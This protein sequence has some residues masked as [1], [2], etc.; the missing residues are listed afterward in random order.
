MI[1]AGDRALVCAFV[2]AAIRDDEDIVEKYEAL[3]AVDDRGKL[4]GGFVYYNYE[5]KP[6]GGNVWIACAGH[7]PW[8]TRQNLRVW[9]EYPFVQLGC[10]RCTSLIAKSNRKS[11]DLVE[12]LGAKREGC[13]RGAR[14]PGKDSIIY[15]LL[16]EEAERWIK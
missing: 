13:I 4:I 2:N 16:R 9:F 15:G 12:R 8:L 6:D 7:G 1:L 3:G 14:G 10:H 5:K 11:R